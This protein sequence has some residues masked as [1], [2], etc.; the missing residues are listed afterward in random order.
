MKLGLGSR[1]WRWLCV[2]AFRRLKARGGRLPDGVP[3]VR[4]VDHPCHAYRPGRRSGEPAGQCWGDGHYLCAECQ[5][6]DVSNDLILF[7]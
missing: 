5:D 1:F 2:F 7:G 3:C 4:D 6:Y